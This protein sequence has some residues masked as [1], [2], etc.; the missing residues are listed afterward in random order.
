MA[1][2][3]NKATFLTHLHDEL[4]ARSH[5]HLLP[6]FSEIRLPASAYLTNTTILEFNPGSHSTSYSMRST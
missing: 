4:L 5:S 6:D 3:F 2:L 1:R